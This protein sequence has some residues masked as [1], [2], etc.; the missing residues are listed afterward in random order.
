MSMDDVRR[1]LDRRS[2]LKEMAVLGVSGTVLAGC[3]RAAGAGGVAAAGAA[4]SIAPAGR[5]GM[6]TLDR[7][8][9]QLYSVMDQMRQDFDGTLEKVARIGYR[10]VEFAGYFDRTPEQVRATLDRVKLTSPSAHI[11]MNLLRSD[12]DAQIRAAQTIGQRYITVPSLGRSD[13]P[14]HEADSWKRIAEEFNRIGATLK[15]AG[16]KLAF[17]N[18]SA[19][20]VDVGGGRTGMDVFIAETDPSLV[21]FEMDLMWAR[22]ANQDPL[23]WFQKYPGRIALWHVKD[24]QQLAAAQEQQAPGLRNPPPPRPAPGAG[25]G[26]P[27]A[28]AG[29]IAPVGAGEIDFRPIFAQWRASGLEYYF[30]EH[31]QAQSWPGGSLASIE[32]SYQHIRQLLG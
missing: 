23:A 20:F 8:G 5:G 15:N 19:E 13:S 32:A 24:M 10:H 17:H 25:G 29:K 31:D 18:H 30:V 26:G 16:L 7:I 28:R 12:L 4:A 1:E 22:V 3:A 21:S 2:F 14:W 6:P 11:G 9:V 27:P